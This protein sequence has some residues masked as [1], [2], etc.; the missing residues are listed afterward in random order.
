MKFSVITPV[1]KEIQNKQIPS[2]YSI[3]KHF[4]QLEFILS[5]ILEI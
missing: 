4:N 2:T 1:A 5:M 3:T